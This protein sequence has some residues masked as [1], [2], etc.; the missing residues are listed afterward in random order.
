MTPYR[1]RISELRELLNQHNHL[2]YTLDDPI[3]TDAEYDLL[4]RELFSLEAT[5]PELVTPDSPTMTVGAPL[6]PDMKEVTHGTPMLSLANAFNEGELVAFDQRVRKTIQGEYTYVCEPKMDGL[7]L[8][9]QYRNGQLTRAAT[10]GD[11]DHG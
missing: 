10:R 7:A 3:I 1:K 9:L 11:G 2:Y 5:H 6:T 8:N 4:Y